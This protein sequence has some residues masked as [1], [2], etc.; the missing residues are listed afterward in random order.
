MKHDTFP[1]PATIGA[2]G[3]HF[4]L[5]QLLKHNFVAGF[6]P[7]NTKDYDI[8]VLNRDGNISFP[9]QVKTVLYNK[10]L[11]E[12]EWILKDKHEVPIKNLIFCFVR[13]N[14]DSKESNV[15]I[16]DS[17]KVA[18]LAKKCHEIWLKIPGLKN[19]KHNDTNM[20]KMMSDF[21]KTIGKRK[22]EDL[23]DYLNEEDINFMENHSKG[24]MDKYEDNWSILKTNE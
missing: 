15:Y 4:V 1:Q 22:Y 16:M 20:R 24:W 21:R 9:V 18:H 13:L 6:A 2:M 3:E 11:T 19:Q 17:N 12:G 5:S 10:T 7:H 8:V 14:R 23:K